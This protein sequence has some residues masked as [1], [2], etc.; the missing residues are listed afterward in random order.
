MITVLMNEIMNLKVEFWNDFICTV[1]EIMILFMI[2]FMIFY[3]MRIHSIQTLA[4]FVSFGS[5][6][7]LLFWISLSFLVSTN[8]SLEVKVF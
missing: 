5:S 3:E 7:V 2:L 1:D 4:F 8:F 6:V